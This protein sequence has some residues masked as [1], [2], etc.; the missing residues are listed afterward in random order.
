MGDGFTRLVTVEEERL[1]AIIQGLG[2][3]HV[4]GGAIKP[5][6]GSCTRCGAEEDAAEFRSVSAPGDTDD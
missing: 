4:C 2:R 6:R 5:G 1:R 3:P